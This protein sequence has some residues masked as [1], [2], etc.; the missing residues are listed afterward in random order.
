ML[1]MSMSCRHLQPKCQSS[2]VMSTS[3]LV[4]LQKIVKIQ[5]KIVSINDLILNYDFTKKLPRNI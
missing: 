5:P 2:S 3:L 1:D 4:F